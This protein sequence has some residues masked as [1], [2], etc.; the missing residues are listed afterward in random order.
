MSG[1]SGTATA[2]QQ[3]AAQQSAAQL[4]A[5]AAAHSAHNYHP[6][7]VMISRAEGAWVTDVEG[8]PLPRHAGRLL[9]HSTSATGTRA[10]SRPRSVSSSGL[11]LISRA[12]EHD[13]FGPFCADLAALCR[14][15]HGPADEHRR[16]GGGDRRSRPRA[17]GA[18]RSRACPTAG[19]D[20]RL[21]RNNFHGRTTTI[22][23][24]STDPDARG[25]LRAVHAGV[26]DR[27]L[28]RR[29][30]A[31]RAGDATPTIV[32]FLSSPFRARPGWS[33]RPPDS[34]PASARS[35]RRTTS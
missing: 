5:Q 11:T 13:Q 26:P 35:A 19:Q 28:R 6:L 15:G 24:F 32:A 21:R 4:R 9:G 23:S 12:F 14:H 22:I 27:P 29:R 20:R 10:W 3:S 31:E 1:I 2:A 25:V 8:Q 7:P 33:C 18:T 17:S 30:R 34:W 16:R